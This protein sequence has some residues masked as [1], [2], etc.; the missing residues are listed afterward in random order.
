MLWKISEIV[1][2][3]IYQYTKQDRATGP[4]VLL[5][6]LVTRIYISMGLFCSEKKWKWIIM[7]KAIK[8]AI[9]YFAIAI[10]PGTS[11]HLRFS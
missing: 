4:Q 5:D 8:I 6:A 11:H 3:N 7:A 1:F 10:I 9:K 2:K